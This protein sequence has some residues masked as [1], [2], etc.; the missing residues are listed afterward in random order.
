METAITQLSIIE[1]RNIVSSSHGFSSI[2]SDA[3]HESKHLC[4]K[5][6][7]EKVYKTHTP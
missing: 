6:I 1:H 4:R 5:F 3:W 7:S 2:L